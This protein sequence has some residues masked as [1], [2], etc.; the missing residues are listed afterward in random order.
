P[1]AQKIT[2]TREVL[3]RNAEF[4]KVGDYYVD[5][6]GII[7]K[8]FAKGA[9]GEVSLVRDESAAIGITEAGA[10][11]LEE[12][13]AT[14]RPDQSSAVPARKFDPNERIYDFDVSSAARTDVPPIVT[15]ILDD[16]HIPVHERDTLIKLIRENKLAKPDALESFARQM[17]DISS[18]WDDA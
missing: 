9:K 1:G 13:A 18:R 6:D 12:G 11:K 3:E 4:K 15:R 7:Y 16:A 5:S 17:R 14:H 8:E 10:R 2:V